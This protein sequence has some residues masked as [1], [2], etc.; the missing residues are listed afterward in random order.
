MTMYYLTGDGTMNMLN[1][2]NQNGQRAEIK[3]ES[4]VDF[5]KI[6]SSKPCTILHKGI[7]PMNFERHDSNMVCNQSKIDRHENDNT[8]TYCVLTV[9]AYG[10]SAR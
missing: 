10:T 9:I 4:V 5:C 1:R 8:P 6:K 2:L 3:N 7:S